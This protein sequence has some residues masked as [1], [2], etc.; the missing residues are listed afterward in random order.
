[1]KNGALQ[2]LLSGYQNDKLN[3]E[4]IKTRQLL[5]IVVPGR[6]DKKKKEKTERKKREH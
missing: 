2:G 3:K 1:M 6:R 4:K 5:A